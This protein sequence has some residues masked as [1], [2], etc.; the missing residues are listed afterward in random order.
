MIPIYIY[1]N[2]FWW[3]YLDLRLGYF[4]LAEAFWLYRPRN[5]IRSKFFIVII[6]IFGGLCFDIFHRFFFILQIPCEKWVLFFK[7]L[8][9]FRKINELFKIWLFLLRFVELMCFF[10]IT[11]LIE[12]HLW[13]CALFP[14]IIGYEKTQF[15]WLYEVIFGSVGFRSCVFFIYLWYWNWWFFTLDILFS[16]IGIISFLRLHMLV[17]FRNFNQSFPTWIFNM[18][19]IMSM[20]MLRLNLLQIDILIRFIGKIEVVG[21]VFFIDVEGFFVLVSFEIW[22]F[23][24]MC[25]HLLFINFFKIPWLIICKI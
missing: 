14:F 21:F 18:T 4:P 24:Y 25:W 12:K 7:F 20:P 8:S 15:V 11:G 16:Q 19:I 9:P 17:K 3:A 13:N 23:F 2:G 10:P 5:F 22:F 6:L 1:Q